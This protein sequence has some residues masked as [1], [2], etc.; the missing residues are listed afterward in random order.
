MIS[1]IRG[2]RAHLEIRG[3]PGAAGVLICERLTRGRL[4]MIDRPAVAIGRA[5]ACKATHLAVGR[6]PVSRSLLLR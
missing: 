3:G 4:L 1:W 5:A 2:R 6:P